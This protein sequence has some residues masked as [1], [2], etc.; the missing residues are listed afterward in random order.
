MPFITGNLYDIADGVLLFN[1]SNKQTVNVMR[2]PQRAEDKEEDWQTFSIVSESLGE[3]YSNSTDILD[4]GL[5]IRENDLIAVVTV[6]V[7]LLVHQF[8]ST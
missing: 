7:L 4:F 1:D 8:P 6:Y 2:L 5:S 3:E